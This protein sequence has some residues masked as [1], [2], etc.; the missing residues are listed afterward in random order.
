MQGGVNNLGA[1]GAGGA[2]LGLLGP[3]GAGDYAGT[4][5]PD[6]IASLRVDQAWGLFQASF[7]AHNN[8]AAY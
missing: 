2:V 8:H 7:A 1:T 3:Y 6:L 5:A 4:I